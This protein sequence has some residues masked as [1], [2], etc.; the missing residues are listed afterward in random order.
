M[1]QRSVV[2]RGCGCSLVPKSYRSPSLKMRETSLKQSQ[3]D[4]AK[5]Q[6]EVQKQRTICGPSGRSNPALGMFVDR[7]RSRIEKSRISGCLYLKKGIVAGL[8]SDIP[9]RCGIRSMILS[10]I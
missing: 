8:L 10:Q 3:R 4:N 6:I 2:L 1:L 7:E 5:K 9:Q